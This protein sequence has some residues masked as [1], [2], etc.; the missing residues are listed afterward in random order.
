MSPFRFFIAALFFSVAASAQVLNIESQRF[1]NDTDGWA[2]QAALN[3]SAQQNVNEV[4]SFGNDVHVQYKKG[5]SRIIFL[6]DLNFSKSNGTSFVNTGY[7][8]LRYNY[9]LANKPHLT[10]EAF[11][12]SQYNK[13]MKMDLRLVA[14]TGP[15][16]RLAKTDRLHLY[17]AALYM[18]EH[19]TDHAD[20]LVYDDH[21]LS[22]YLS[23]S[24]T[25][26]KNAEIVNT[27]YYQPAFADF[28]DY[29]IAEDFHFTID[30]S[31]HFGFGTVFS[32]LQDTKQP[33]GIPNLSWQ[34]G[35]QLSFS[36]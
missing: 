16:F 3:F 28:N 1:L 27:L 26:F 34:L 22:S 18:F 23:F 13:P 2:G 6:N 35:Q 7:Q 12:Q 21:R 36:F 9:K 19:E 32:L 15:R 31:K 11:V 30:I 5:K 17:F 25:P 20:D 33:P 14:G 4:I 24:W 29:R 10:W 8:H